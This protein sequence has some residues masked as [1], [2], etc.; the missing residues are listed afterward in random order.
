M[1]KFLTYE[2]EIIQTDENYMW[3]TEHNQ[4]F[5]DVDGTIYLVPRFFETDGYTII[6]LFAPIAGNRLENDIRP[7][8]QHDWDC[9]YKFSLVVKLNEYE[10]RQKN[11]LRTIFKQIGKEKIQINVCEDIPVRY[12]KV[13]P[14]GFKSA[15]FK[16]KRMLDCIDGM[17]TWK[18]RL[19]SIAVF[20]NIGWFTDKASKFNVKKLYKDIM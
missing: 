13:I 17:Q 15:N 8:V 3:T 6:N 18:K 5:Q 12:L 1:A 7:A 14:V 10:L 4:L 11:Y 2:T 16:L 9:K 20:L 19:I